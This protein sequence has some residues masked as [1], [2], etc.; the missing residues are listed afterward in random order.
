MYMWYLHG[1]KRPKEAKLN[2]KDEALKALARCWSVIPLL[3][4]S[5]EPHPELLMDTDGLGYGWTYWLTARPDAKTVKYWFEVDPNANLAVVC[6]GISGVIVLDIDAP[7]ALVMLAALL[8]KDF[9]MPIVKTSRGEHWYF[10]FDRQTMNLAGSG[11]GFDIRSDN[12]YAVLPGSTH[13]DGHVYSWL[14]EPDGDLPDMPE[15][16]VK[17]L[18]ENATLDYNNSPSIYLDADD[19]DDFDY[20]DD[21]DFDDY[22]DDYEGDDHDPDFDDEI[23]V[24]VEVQTYKDRT[25]GLLVEVRTAAQDEYGAALARVQVY[26]NKIAAEADPNWDWKEGD[27][28]FVVRTGYMPDELNA[29][30]ARRLGCILLKAADLVNERERQEEGPDIRF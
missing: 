8:P 2:V 24:D 30:D 3:P 10:K 4:Q 14:V 13:K 26:D 1:H 11:R 25:D 19:Y 28:R 15:A 21:D 27:Q 16:L 29:D 7:E 9:K 18:R 12:Y 5:K 6:G 17:Y 22:D 20:G 23:E